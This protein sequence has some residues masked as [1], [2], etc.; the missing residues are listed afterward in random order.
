MKR[1]GGKEQ[2]ISNTHSN[3]LISNV[4]NLMSC[5]REKIKVS[6][7][8]K[9]MTYFLSKYWSTIVKEYNPF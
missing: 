9:V 6:S 7:H 1:H 5:K 3:R 2:Q 4:S 8:N